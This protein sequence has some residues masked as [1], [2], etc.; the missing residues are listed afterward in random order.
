ME[1]RYQLT[2]KR[3]ISER[4]CAKCK[5]REQ[6]TSHKSP[7]PGTWHNEFSGE[8]KYTFLDTGPTM[9]Q[10]AGGRR[11]TKRKSDKATQSKTS[12]AKLPSND[13]TTHACGNHL[14]ANSR[15]PS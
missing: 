3:A 13:T 8:N 2:A 6:P 12:R 15:S 1:G 4:V 11:Q 14:L 10:E 7:P 5:Y 9:N